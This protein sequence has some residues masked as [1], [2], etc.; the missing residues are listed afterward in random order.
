MLIAYAK[1][2]AA[3]WQEVSY[4]AAPVPGHRTTFSVAQGGVRNEGTAVPTTNASALITSRYP[5]PIAAQFEILLRRSFLLLLKNPMTYARPMMAVLFGIICGSLFGY[6]S[7]GIMGYMG[8]LG[9]LF[10]SLQ[11]SAMLAVSVTMPMTV[12]SRAAM[13]KH[14]DAEL[15][16]PIVFHLSAWICELPAALLEATILSSIPYWWIGLREDSYGYFWATLFGI[17]LVA[18]AIG[19]I[20][21]AMLPTQQ[22][23]TLAT[24]VAA[25][26]MGMFAGYMPTYNSVGWWWRWISWINPMAYA[27]EGI[28]ISQFDGLHLS[29]ATVV[30]DDGEVLIGGNALPGSTW[31]RV[32]SIPRIPYD[33]A[34]SS[35]ST[36]SGV[37]S[38]NLGM[39]FV[40]AF[41]IEVGAWAALRSV[42][43]RFGRRVLEKRCQVSS[44]GTVADTPAV[45][46]GS[47]RDAAADA[48]ESGGEVMPA[49]WPLLELSCHDLSYKVDMPTGDLLHN[50]SAAASAASTKG[51]AA[52]SAVASAAAHATH[53]SWTRNPEGNESNPES[54]ESNPEGNECRQPEQDGLPDA[55]VECTSTGGDDPEQLCLLH[56]VNTSFTS[57]EMTALMGESGAGKTTLLDVVAG[58]KTSGQISGQVR[59]NGQVID[60]PTW[61]RL[62]AY[63]EQTDIH[64]PFLSVRESFVFAALCRAPTKLTAAAGAAAAAEMIRYSRLAP[65]S[66]FNTLG[67]ISD[68]DPVYHRRLLSLDTHSDTLVDSAMPLD[69]LKR[70]TIG[71]ELL[72]Q[73][74]MLFA[75]EPTTG[76]NEA[77]AQLVMGALRNVATAKALMVVATIHQP[78][79]EIF[80][81]FDNLLVLRRGG[82]LPPP[83]LAPPSPMTSRRFSIESHGLCAAGTSPTTVP[84]VLVRRRCSA[85]RR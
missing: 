29:I 3:G 51:R 43:G 26:L 62:A 21:A 23:G 10:M 12:R 80:E 71:V 13:V 31:C 36:P 63:A 46:R 49:D 52:A 73:P 33:E 14:C 44:S 67:P 82:Y 66:I 18:Q 50:A 5:L 8:M 84:S 59:L 27:F 9:Y 11:L 41:A 78:S 61:R 54:N 56:G 48:A 64:E 58:Y 37:M 76:L 20:S 6:M 65:Q 15:Y 38:F 85:T 28:M 40:F 16:S 1:S 68:L 69:A 2:K 45:T 34:S 53:V 79:R 55:S 42:R 24:T 77:G 19:R 25:M 57:G 47:A 7:A 39:L 70:V 17:E 74:R 30:T 75:D 72:A 22:H 83:F 35:L 81:A 4:V 60:A 32:F